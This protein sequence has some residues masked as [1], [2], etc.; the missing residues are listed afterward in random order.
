MTHYLLLQALVGEPSKAIAGPFETREMCET[1]KI[2]Y[3]LTIDMV[4]YARYVKNNS[5]TCEQVTYGD[6]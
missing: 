3:L 5:L 4:T 1:H 2:N 6:K